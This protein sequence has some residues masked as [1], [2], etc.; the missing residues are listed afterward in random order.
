MNRLCVFAHYDRDGLIEDYVLYYLQAL[1]EVCY[2]IIFVSDCDIQATELEK[3]FPITNMVLAKRHGEYDFG[4]YKRGFLLAQD[5]NLVFDE[6]ILANDS[7]YGPINSLQ[8]VF[9]KMQKRNCDYWGITKNYLGIKKRGDD[10]FEAYEPHLQSY[11]LVLKKQVFNSDCFKTFLNSIVT[12]R[13]KNDIIIKYE[14]GLSSILNKNK[15]KDAVFINDFYHLPDALLVNPEKMLR[16]GCPFLKVSTVKART[17]KILIGNKQLENLI[18]NHSSRYK[19]ELVKDFDYTLFLKK[20][21]SVEIYLLIR[22]IE[23][24]VL[25]SIRRV[26]RNILKNF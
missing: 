14:Q 15:F 13:E 1:K 9:N 11:F 18:E 3:L 12:Q 4:S 22:F 20:Y 24:K 8:T 6:L 16:K 10:F 26:V 5:L 17:T 19:R 25:F 2:D 7:C 21:L 23:R